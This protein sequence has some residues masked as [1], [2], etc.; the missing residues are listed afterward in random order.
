LSLKH[1]SHHPQVSVG[2]RVPG[3]ILWPLKNFARW[4]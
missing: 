1:I 2:E 4:H 3:I